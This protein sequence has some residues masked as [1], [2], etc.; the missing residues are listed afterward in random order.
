M[1]C[2]SLYSSEFDR[3]FEEGESVIDSLGLSAA[4]RPRLEQRR[5][6]VDF[7]RRPHMPSDLEYNVYV[8]LPGSTAFVTA[9]W[10]LPG[11]RSAGPTGGR[12]ID[13]RRYR[14]RPDAV[15]L[16]PVQLML[17]QGCLNM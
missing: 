14:E 13:G 16:D 5:V 17:R 10:F 8:V 4:R 12:F 6:N 15:E 3:R 11:P 2:S 9:G 7:R 1:M